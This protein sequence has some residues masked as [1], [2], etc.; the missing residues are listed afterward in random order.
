M[1]GS[2]QGSV[3]AGSSPGS[4]VPQADGG[5]AQ[6]EVAD[7]DLQHAGGQAYHHHHPHAEQ[8]AYEQQAWTQV[9]EHQQQQ[10]Q[11]HQQ[12]YAEP[13]YTPGH[14][15]MYDLAPASSSASS[16]PHASLHSSPVKAADDAHHQH[17]Q[18]QME[19]YGLFMSPYAESLHNNHTHVN[20]H[21]HAHAHTTTSHSTLAAA[22]AAESHALRQY[23]HAHA[24]TYS[25][26]AAYGYNVPQHDAPPTTRRRLGTGAA[27]PS[28]SRLRR[29][30]ALPLH[31]DAV[32]TWL[33]SIA[34]HGRGSGRGLVVGCFFL[35]VAATSRSAP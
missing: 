14:G 27:A 19:M 30:D 11:P 7:A 4:Y 34:K 23:H 10:H 24:V 29:S 22:A 2:L 25:S 16:S 35:A 20:A 8:Q 26:E 1:R 5:A 12:Q 15:G 31:A 28:G 9:V 33:G 17:Q 13:P 21:A 32:T 3:G 6:Y 18:Q